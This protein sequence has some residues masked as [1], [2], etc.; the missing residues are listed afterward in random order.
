ML[1]PSD[2]GPAWVAL[3][4]PS[5]VGKTSVVRALA[6]RT[7]RTELAEAYDSVVDVPSLEFDTRADLLRIERR[8]VTLELRRFRA[9]TGF[10]TRGVPLV[11][12][13]GFLGPLTYSMG[14]REELGS[15][16][17]VVDDIRRQF[18]RAA[19]TGDWGIPDLTLYLEAPAATIRERTLSAP[20]THPLHLTER[21][22]RVAR[23]ERVYWLERVARAVPGR[24]LRVDATGDVEATVDRILRRLRETALRP[25]PTN[26]AARAVLAALGD[27]P[28]P[29]PSTALLATLKKGT[30]SP[31]PPRR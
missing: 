3:E 13:T 30:L 20:A 5:G 27:R 11:L 25:R 10:R 22:A 6:G 2:G 28:V 14:L 9:A 21:H 29:R 16:W 19:G 7:G 24:V 18:T 4:G 12:D 26:G 8:L 17:D 31:R 23:R 15:G 1:P